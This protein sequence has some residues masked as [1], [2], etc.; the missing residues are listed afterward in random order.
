ML[1]V[2]DSRAF[3]LLR[4]EEGHGGL[5]RD[6]GLGHRLRRCDYD[7][8]ITFGLP[9][10]VNDGVLDRVH[11]L[12]GHT[13]FLYPEDLE[14]CGLRLFR[15]RVSVDL[16]TQEGSFT[17]PVQLGV[18]D[19]EEVQCPDDLLGRNAHEANLGRVAPDLR[20]PEAEELLVS[21]YSFSL[22]R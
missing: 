4:A 2:A 1:E 17:L 3:A 13:L 15:L 14:R 8:P 16:D 22:R 18:S 11:N 20:G 21:L 10:K 12:D 9:G 5:G 19:T 6:C 7:E